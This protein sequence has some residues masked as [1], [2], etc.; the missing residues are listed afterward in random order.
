MHT[1]S[2]ATP[3]GRR[4]MTLA[5]IRRQQSVAEL[6]AGKTCDKWKVKRDASAAME[7]L[8]LQ[9]NSLAVLD[10][11]LSF[12]PENELRQDGQLVVYPSNLQL[13]LRANGM[14]GSTL[15]RHLALLVEA[16][17]IM[18]KD[19]ANGK[20]YAR[21]DGAG[22]VERAF[23]FDLA[24]LLARAEELAAMAQEVI[25]ARTR[26]R[27][28]KED[29]TICRRDV[30]KLITAA[31]EE[32]V[33][34]GDWYAIEAAYTAIVGRLPRVASLG[35]VTRALDE[36]LVLRTEILNRLEKHDKSVFL[37]TNDA[38]IER[39][40]HNS[41]PDSPNEFEQSSEKELEAKSVEDTRAKKQSREPLKVFA[42]GTVL[43]ACP[44]IVGY[45][46][47][48][49]ITSWRDFMSA[50]VVVR[51]MLGITPSAYQQACDV[52]GQENAAVSVA[53]ML[54][55]ANMINSPGGYLRDLTGRAQRGAFS[56]GPMLMALLKANADSERRV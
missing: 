35:E 38:H 42:L 2:V 39:H 11:L 43:R 49:S 6:K 44:Q 18:R 17:L 24:P 27:K 13:S 48:G 36:M 45:G 15:R 40:I 52:M 8:G 56:L 9:S 19:S 54:E 7:Q 14:P 25:A 32:D 53:C 46:P 31:I 5:L 3:F 12:Y 51:S 28:S 10:A 34:G 55:R 21:K 33:E 23:G 20:R 4:P 29:L 1:E 50:G 41:N 37:G 47:G 26:L 16:G 22:D 30:R